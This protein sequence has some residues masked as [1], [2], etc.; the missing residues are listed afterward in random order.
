MVHAVP[1]ITVTGAREGQ[2]EHLFRAPRLLKSPVIFNYHLYT[3]RHID[4]LYQQIIN[5]YWKAISKFNYS[6]K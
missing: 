2:M 3:V 1:V 5:L 4:I 6:T